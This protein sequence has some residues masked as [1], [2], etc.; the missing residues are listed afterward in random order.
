[1]DCENFTR[2]SFNWEIRDIKKPE[3]LWIFVAPRGKKV[4]SCERL[5]SSGPNPTAKVATLGR[6]RTHQ[7]ITTS[8]MVLTV[9]HDD[10][11]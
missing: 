8:R 1:M 6:M 11:S 10:D 4:G 9:T 2:A 5:S 7:K 3:K